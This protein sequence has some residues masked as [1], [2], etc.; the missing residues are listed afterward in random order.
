MTNKKI[1]IILGLALSCT[2]PE[3]YPLPEQLPLSPSGIEIFP[4]EMAIRTGEHGQIRAVLIQSDGV[5]TDIPF[6]SLVLDS[7]TDAVAFDQGSI[8]GIKEGISCVSVSYLDKSSC[9][10]VIVTIP[11]DYSK[12]RF[13][14]HF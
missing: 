3:R 2:I 11:P 9:L 10:T 4:A 5:K 8:L 13:F 1:I 7:D 14:T 6:A 12:L